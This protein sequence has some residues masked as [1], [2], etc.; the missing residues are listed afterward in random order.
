MCQIR[1]AETSVDSIVEVVKNLYSNFPNRDTSILLAD[2][3]R[4]E[5]QSDGMISFLIRPL[6]FTTSEGGK[7]LPLARRVYNAIE[8]E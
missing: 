6:R 8:W 3:S 2:D 4:I 1:L 7:S 5:I